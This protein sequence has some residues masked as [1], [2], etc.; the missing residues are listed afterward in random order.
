MVHLLEHTHCRVSLIVILFNLNIRLYLVFFNQF[1]RNLNLIHLRQLRC[2]P[3]TLIQNVISVVLLLKQV[4]L[5]LEFNWVSAEVK[6]TTIEVIYAERACFLPKINKIAHGYFRFRAGA[7]G[8]PQRCLNKVRVLACYW[9]IHANKSIIHFVLLIYVWVL[10]IEP[11]MVQ[12][13]CW[14]LRQKILCGGLGC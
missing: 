8:W 4:F 3:F 12:I 9:R 1:L 6:L 5:F 11:E 13:I 2:L 10:L 14:N 7:L